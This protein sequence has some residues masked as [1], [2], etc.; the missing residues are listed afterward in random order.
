MLPETKLVRENIWPPDGKQPTTPPAEIDEKVL[1]RD[2]EMFFRV[3][4]SCPEPGASIGYRL[5]E[6]KQYAGPWQVY[7]GPF[8]VPGNL[9]FIEVQTHRIGHRPATNGA[10]LGRE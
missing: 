6:T 8:D 2:G 3:S 10:F 9:R 7:T 1:S 5:S 4:L